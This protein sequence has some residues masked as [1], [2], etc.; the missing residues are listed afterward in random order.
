MLNE[1]YS[2]IFYHHEL[3]GNAFMLRFPS[4]K[5]YQVCENILTISLTIAV[6]DLKLNSKMYNFCLLWATFQFFVFCKVKW[7]IFEDFHTALEEKEAITV[8]FKRCTAKLYWHL[9]L[10]LVVQRPSKS[11]AMQLELHM[12]T[13]KLVDIAKNFEASNIVVVN[14]SRISW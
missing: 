14:K 11:V 6:L 13:V 10:F 7:E 8:F 12:W 3:D 9:G 5:L 1:T 4:Q 2:V